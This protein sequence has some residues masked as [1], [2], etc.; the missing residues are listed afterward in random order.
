MTIARIW[1]G[2][3][4]AANADTY[5]R[6]LDEFVIPAHMRAAGSEGVILLNEP[7]GELI[8]FMLLSLWESEAAL[9]SFTGAAL[10]EVVELCPEERKI[11]LAFESTARHYRV[12]L[13]SG[14]TTLESENS[15]A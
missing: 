5:I 3:T 9:E 11:L 14:L 4:L 10:C 2:I 8:H 7:Q 15:S 13:A 1:R 6:Y 12:V